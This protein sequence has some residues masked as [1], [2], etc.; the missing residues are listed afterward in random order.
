M[1][2]SSQIF[3]PFF[4]SQVPQPP[5]PRPND[6]YARL[7]KDDRKV[8]APVGGGSGAPIWEDDSAV[9]VRER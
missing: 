9:V 8:G 5:P 4:T 3:S 1:R 7:E 6:T 2:L